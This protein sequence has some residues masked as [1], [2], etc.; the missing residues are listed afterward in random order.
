MRML[1][2]SS[3]FI[4]LASAFMLYG[5]NYETRMTAQ[6]VQALERRAEQARSDISVLKAERAHLARPERIEPLARA[7]GLA[8]ASEAQ[9]ARPKNQGG[10]VTGS[11]DTR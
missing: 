5:L 6:N 2:I 4:A 7:Q 10:I 8:P 1:T 3:V 11:T 9:L